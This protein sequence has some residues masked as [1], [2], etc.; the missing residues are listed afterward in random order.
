MKDHKMTILT[1][2]TYIRPN[3]QLEWH[4]QKNTMEEYSSEGVIL[5]IESQ[6]DTIR[7]RSFEYTDDV[8]LVVSVIWTDKEQFDE[9][10]NN[11]EILKYY[12]FVDQYYI[13][14]GGSVSER[15]VQEI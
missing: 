3:T 5:A 4:T 9:Y 11:P 1:H 13:A 2:K 14:A 7:T 10:W 6:M 15:L 8:T 12:E